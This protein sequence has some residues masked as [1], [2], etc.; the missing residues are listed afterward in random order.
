VGMGA[1][2][3]P[4][5]VSTDDERPEGIATAEP[6]DHVVPGR[7]R[8]ALVPPRL[9]VEVVAWCVGYLALASILVYVGGH[10]QIPFQDTANANPGGGLIPAVRELLGRPNRYDYLLDYASAHA[11]THGA[12][13]YASPVLLIHGIGPSWP[14]VTG[15]N[16]HPPTV[17]TLVLPFTVVSYG[18]SLAAWALAMVGAF[19]A[20]LRLVG[21]PLRSLSRSRVTPASP[22]RYRS[23][24]SASR[25]PTG[26]GTPRSSPAWA[27]HSRQHRKVPG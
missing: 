3:P 9:V 18:T 10:Y 19:L 15:A 27:S 8:R 25:S 12:D 16:P 26:T 4:S 21:V 23:S 11:L 2:V 5:S 24:A 20:T 22:T 17:L 1:E 6:V 7:P 14:A 13:A